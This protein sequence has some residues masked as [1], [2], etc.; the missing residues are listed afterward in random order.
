MSTVHFK[1]NPVQLAG[2]LPQIGSEAP[3]F[4]LAA[5]DLSDI[6][7]H[8]LLGKRVVLNIFP[9]LDTDVCAASVR[10]FNVEASKL[11]NTVVLCVSMDLPFAAARFCVANGIENVTTAS[12]FRSAFGRDY[13]VEIADGPLR[14]LL[15]RA[16]VVLDTAGRVAGVSVC[17]EI[18]E[19]PDYDF[20]KNLLKE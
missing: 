20:V 12:A 9:S 15:A 17:D 14:G 18:T 8:E 10:R 13:G 16:V 11:K 2:E 1:G 4:A 3:R 5:Q 19:E 6:D 7:L